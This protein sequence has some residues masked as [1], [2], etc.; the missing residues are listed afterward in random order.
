ML[1]FKMLT[2]QA[3]N[4]EPVLSAFTME[5]ILY[6]SNDNSVKMVS[7]AVHFIILLVV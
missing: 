1:R 5:Q 2:L 7:V 3:E 6:V 4:C